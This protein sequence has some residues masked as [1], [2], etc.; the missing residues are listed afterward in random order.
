LPNLPSLIKSALQ[1]KGWHPSN[2]VIE[3]GMNPH[4]IKEVKDFPFLVF[5]PACGDA[6]LVIKLLG[7]LATNGASDE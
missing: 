1:H 2:L 7:N 4:I 6:D 5:S 3:L